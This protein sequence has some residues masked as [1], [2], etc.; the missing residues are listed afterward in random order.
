[1]LGDAYSQ[2]CN[3][4]HTCRSYSMSKGCNTL[5]T[6]YAATILKTLMLCIAMLSQWCAYKGAWGCHTAI[7][8]EIARKLAKVGYA[9][10][11]LAT[12]LLCDPFLVTVLGQM[13][14]N[15]PSHWKV[16]QHNPASTITH[17]NC[18]TA[19]LSLLNAMPKLRLMHGAEKN[20]LKSSKNIRRPLHSKS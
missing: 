9:A 10:R 1:M 14:K 5:L 16:S 8:F 4:I 13:A 7:P 12:L 2:M 11:P 20:S 6:L 3:H 15:T 17:K 18:E 19:A